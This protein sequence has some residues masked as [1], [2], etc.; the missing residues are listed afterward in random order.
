MCHIEDVSVPEFR[1][2]YLLVLVLCFNQDEGKNGSG[3]G[4]TFGE[5]LKKQGRDRPL[6]LY[7]GS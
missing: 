7:T 6:A 5:I 1:R 2:E 4:K 3:G